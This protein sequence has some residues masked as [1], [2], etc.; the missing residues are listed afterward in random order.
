MGTSVSF[1]SPNTPRWQAL[2]T[3]L[4]T[5]ESFDRIRSELFN[6][7]E[8]WGEEFAHAAIAP[9]VA[10]LLRAYDTLAETLGQVD[11]PERAVLPIVREARAEAI[12]AG[13]PASLAIAERALMRTLVEA[14]RADA[15]LSEISSADAARAWEV[16]RGPSAAAFAQRYLGEV[17]RQFAL[18]TVSRDAASVFRRTQDAGASRDFARA[19]SDTAAAVAGSAQFDEQELRQQPARAWAVAVQSAFSTG[20]KLPPR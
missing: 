16:N 17:L 19:V 14:M 1:R 10:G 9:F 18:H 11:R 3:S 6:A 7:G 4:E 15:P 5:S 20:R 13:A 8:S 12:A 2:R